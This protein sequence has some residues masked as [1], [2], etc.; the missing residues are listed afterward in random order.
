ML[1][2]FNISI[3]TRTRVCL[4]AIILTE[5]NLCTQIIRRQLLLLK[6]LRLI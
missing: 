2:A 6:L 4:A 1:H 3:R 5:Q